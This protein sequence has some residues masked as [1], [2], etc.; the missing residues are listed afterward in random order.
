MVF[1]SLVFL[2]LFL[3]ISILLYYISGRRYRNFVL[4]SISLFSYW[5]GET[6]YII[7]MVMSILINY[8]FGLLVDKYRSNGRKAHIIITLSVIGNLSIIGYYKYTNFIIQNINSIYNTEIPFINIIMPIG[9]SFFTFQ[10]LS[11][12]I[13]IYRGHGRV[14]KNP[15][16]V[17]LYISLFPQLIAGPIVRYETVADQINNRQESLEKF[18]YGIERFIIGLSKKV[19]IANSMG[20]IADEVFSNQI[21]EL[22]IVLAWIGGLA[23]AAQIYFDFSGYSDM[24]IGLGRIFGFEFIENFNY[25]YISK[26]ITEFWRRWHI[27]LSTWFRDYVFIPLGGNRSSKLKYL[28]NIFVVWF[29]TGLWHGASWN[30]IA[31]GLYFGILLTI[32]KFILGKYIKRLWNPLQHLYAMI[33]IIIGWVLFRSSTLSYALD[34]IKVMVGLRGQGIMNMQALY[35]LREYKIEFIIAVLFSSPI[36]IVVKNKLGEIKLSKIRGMIKY[37]LKPILFGLLFLLCIMYLINSTFNP[38]IYFRF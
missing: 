28:R 10:G 19:L 11:Y 7:V 30:F 33:F 26:S 32:E 29:L 25:P 20:M 6:K 5:Y 38:F 1:S 2:F 9:I 34:Y 36:Y 14:Q 35:Y 4:L 13:D 23:Y 22:S 3:P 27:S 37:F 15:I 12:V 8:I 16:N 18:E 21:S 31:W 17:A 24:A